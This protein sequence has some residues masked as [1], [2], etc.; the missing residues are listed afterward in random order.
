MHG[1]VSKLIFLFVFFYFLTKP[2][3]PAK[4]DAAGLPPGIVA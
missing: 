2:C 1:A 4:Q 3:V